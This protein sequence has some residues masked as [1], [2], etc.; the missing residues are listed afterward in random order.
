MAGDKCHV[1]F[2]GIPCTLMS[3]LRYASGH[4]ISAL[5]SDFFRVVHGTFHQ[6][7]QI[8]ICTYRS[9]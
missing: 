2:L 4:D 5:G 6:Q 1:Q 7:K 3:A 8:K 9:T